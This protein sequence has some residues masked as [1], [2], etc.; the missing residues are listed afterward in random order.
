[1]A[2]TPGWLPLAL[3]TAVAYGLF[4]VFASQAGGKIG[5]AFGAGL[6]EA[7]AAVV[8][9]V[10]ALA[11]RAST[12]ATAAGVRWSVLAGVFAGI[13]TLAYV[14]MFRRGG[15]L[16]GAGPIAFCGSMVVMVGAGVLV[17]HEPLSARRAAG[18][19]LGMLSIA[20]LK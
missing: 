12:Q 8:I 20:L 9:F 3:V 2:P 15:G 18:L 10:F 1:M 11:T 14:S 4:N 6:L 16:T 5:D 13:G 19:L 7:T 17:F